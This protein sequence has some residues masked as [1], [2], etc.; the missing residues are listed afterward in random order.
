MVNGIAQAPLTGE[1]RSG[2]ASP[3]G[4]GIHVES[5]KKQ[6]LVVTRRQ[7]KLLVR[8]QCQSGVQ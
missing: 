8:A 4:K 5:H 1:T 2:T 6:T 7:T 3:F